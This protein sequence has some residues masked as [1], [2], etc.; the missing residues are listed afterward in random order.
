MADEIKFYASLPPIQSAVTFA[1]SRGDGARIKLDLPA[2]EAEA[3]LLLAHHGRGCLLEVSV[4][5][6]PAETQV[7]N[8]ETERKPKKAPARRDLRRAGN[9]RDQHARSKA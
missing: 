5:F 1:G 7:L 8:D 4:K 2:S 6:L 3:A 9:G